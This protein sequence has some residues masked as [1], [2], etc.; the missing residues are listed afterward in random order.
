VSRG[1]RR[2]RRAEQCDGA[3]PFCPRD[4]RQDVWHCVPPSAGDCDTPELCDG[5][6]AQCGRNVRLSGDVC[7]R[8]LGVC[9]IAEVCDGESDNCPRDLFRTNATECR[10]SRGPCDPAEF[11]DGSTAHCSD[12]NYL[13]PINSPCDDGDLCTENDRCVPGGQCVGTPVTPCARFDMPTPSPAPGSTPAPLDEAQACYM[14]RDNCK[15]CVQLIACGYC[16]THNG[17]AGACNP[18]S[19][20]QQCYAIGGTWNVPCDALSLPPPTPPLTPVPTRPRA[21]PGPPTPVPPTTFRTTAA[22]TAATTSQGP[23]FT[24]RDPFGSLDLP[25]FLTAG[26]N[27]TDTGPLGLG[28]GLVLEWVFILGLVAIYLICCC[29]FGVFALRVKKARDIGQGRR[30]R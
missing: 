25:D 3:Q 27:G 26:G 13:A 2:L 18:A 14:L 5:R 1:G 12:V 28:W 19:V 29:G 30:K 17:Q 7:R 21:S 8:A 22:T 24:V 16:A 15:L 20:E 4:Q 11:C 9:D 6:S 23:V 10:A